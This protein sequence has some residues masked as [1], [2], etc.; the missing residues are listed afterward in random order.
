MEIGDPDRVFAVGELDAFVDGVFEVFKLIWA[1]VPVA[2]QETDGAS[3]CFAL[4][5]EVNEPWP[6]GLDDARGSQLN[7]AGIWLYLFQPQADGFCG[8][9]M[10]VAV[11]VGFSKAEEVGSI[12]CNGGLGVASPC[13]I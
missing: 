5:D 13:S 10:Q 8:L 4:A 3:G 7:A 11:R 1:P 12:I 6:P 9:H 2:G